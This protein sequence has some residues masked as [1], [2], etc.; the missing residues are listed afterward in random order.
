MLNLLP[1]QDKAIIRKEYKLRLLIVLFGALAILLLASAIFLSPVYVALTSRNA[2]LQNDYVSVSMAA[3][4]TDAGV[5]ETIDRG[6][7]LVQALSAPADAIDPVDLIAKVIEAKSGSVKLTSIV[8]STRN[9]G[10]MQLQGTSL[11]REALRDYTKSLQLIPAVKE[12]NLP[13][14]NFARESNI[15]FTMDLTLKQ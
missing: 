2:M 12:I 1:E 11:S 15:P 10:A 7:R 5:Q 3:L 4:Q 13:I 8:F 6:V 9:G 14:S